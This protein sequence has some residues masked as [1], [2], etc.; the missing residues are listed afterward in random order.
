[1]TETIRKFK[2]NM[3]MTP[4][5][6]KDLRHYLGA[7]GIFLLIVFLLLFLSY[8]EIP[9]VNKD[10]FVSVVGMM[11]GS[12]SVVIYTIIG[13]NPEEL[14]SLRNKNESLQAGMQMM[15]VR[16]DQLE[17]MIIQIQKNIITRLTKLGD[18]EDVTC[19]CGQ[20]ECTCKNQ[21]T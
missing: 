18:V 10:V 15:E 4:R 13:K 21:K 9:P 6:A 8:N 5:S 20:S 12:L 2:R 7:A 19:E 17:S 16:N 1:M 14:E 3:S 11:V